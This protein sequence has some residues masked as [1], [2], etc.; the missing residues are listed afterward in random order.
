MNLEVHTWRAGAVTQQR[1]IA[2]D[3]AHRVELDAFLLDVGTGCFG[4]LVDRGGRDAPAVLGV[5]AVGEQD[6]YL[7]EVGGLCRTIGQRRARSKGMP[8]PR[9]S[10][11]CPVRVSEAS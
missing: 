3:H 5:V 2:G 8:R 4:A 11:V 7:V 10:M 1:L 6:D 9:Q